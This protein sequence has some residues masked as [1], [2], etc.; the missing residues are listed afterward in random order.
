M[1]GFLRTVIIKSSFF[2]TAYILFRHHSIIISL[3]A[4]EEDEIWMVD[5]TQ[6]QPIVCGLEEGVRDLVSR[7]PEACPYRTSQLV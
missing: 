4:A 7:A 6:P 3:P 2:I 5:L 1:Y